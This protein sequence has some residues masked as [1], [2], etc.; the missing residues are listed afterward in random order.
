MGG[1]SVGAPKQMVIKGKRLDGRKLD[2]LRPVSIEV[3]VIPNADGSCR[4]RIGGTEVIVGVYGPREM[5]PRRLQEDDR[6]HI[7]CIYDMAA[8]ATSERCRPGPSRR[9]KEI[10]EIMAKALAPAIM[11]EKYPRTGIDVYALVSNANAG[12]RCAAISAAAVAL[13]DAGIEMRDL[14]AAAA[15]GKFDDKIGMDLFNV[16]DNYGQGDVPLAI[17][18]N[19]KQITLLQMDGDMTPAEFKQCLEY[20]FKACKEIYEKQVAALKEKYKV[21]KDGE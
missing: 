9:S 20:N 8:F 4:L 2:E 1:K 15:S 3:G 21:S 19:S 12:T 13:A 10:S 17:M 7:N 11:L 5:F 18:P 6:A 16:E 14:V